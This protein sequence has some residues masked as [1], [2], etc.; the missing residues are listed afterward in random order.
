MQPYSELKAL[1]LAFAHTLWFVAVALTGL[2]TA[3]YAQ[4]TA[5]NY[6]LLFW[7]LLPF[8][9][10]HVALAHHYFN[11]TRDRTRWLACGIECLALGSFAEL[12][13]RVWLSSI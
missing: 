10:L 4:A 12:T 9:C 2:V 11:R 8:A 6:H 1:G 3:F 5:D 13:L 7:V